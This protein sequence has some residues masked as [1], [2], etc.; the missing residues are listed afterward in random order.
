[1]LGV[2]LTV[3]QKN[4]M[5]FFFCAGRVIRQLVIDAFSSH[6]VNRIQTQTLIA[7]FLS[8]S[9]FAF[10]VLFA[11]KKKC[12]I[13]EPLGFRCCCWG[14]QLFAWPFAIVT[15]I[16][17]N[18]S[19][20]LRVGDSSKLSTIQAPHWNPINCYRNKCIPKTCVQMHSLYS[21]PSK[22]KSVCWNKDSP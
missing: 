7:A 1:M 6:L 11:Q 10:S 5:R 15:V 8:V 21:K 19:F 16:S 14:I 4:W 18:W 9:Q 20:T 12:G 13:V 2:F 17:R 3:L 22:T